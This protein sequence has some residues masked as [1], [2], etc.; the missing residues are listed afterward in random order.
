MNNKDVLSSDWHLS[1]VNRKNNWKLKDLPNLTICV[2]NYNSERWLKNFLSHILSLQYPKEKISIHFVDNGST[3]NTVIELEKFI[4]ENRDE[5]QSVKLFEQSNLGYGAGNDI[6]IRASKDE[7]VLVVNVDT[8]LDTLSLLRVVSVAVLDDLKVACWE[9]RQTPYEH[10]KFYDP[11]TLYTNWVSHACVLIRKS[12]YLA[13]GGYDLTIFMYGED[14]EI[15]YRFR[16]HGY[17]LRYIPTAL[18][19]HHVVFDNSDLRPHQISGS[20]AANVLLRY[21]YG[22]MRA[23]IA[24]ELLLF[25][26]SLRVAG[27]RQQQ[28]WKKA[29]SL[30][31][32]NRRHFLNIPISRLKIRF[33]I[34]RL[35]Y[36][37]HRAGYDLK[38]VPFLGDDNTSPLVSVVVYMDEP[39]PSHYYEAI[40]SV[41]NQTYARIEIVLV[42]SNTAEQNR[43]LLREF[44]DYK[45]NIRCLSLQS[46]ENPSLKISTLAGEFFMI[47][48]TNELLFADHVET[49][50]SAL[51]EKKELCAKSLAWIVY[52]KKSSKDDVGLNLKMEEEISDSSYKWGLFRKDNFTEWG[53]FLLVPNVQKFYKRLDVALCPNDILI[54]PKTTSII[55]RVK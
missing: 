26:T 3:D 19:K 24:G 42:G 47:L 53:D 12:A 38:Q 15:S 8:E 7:Y 9:L 37:K 46:D 21:R 2:V 32:K 30:V 54:I 50:M 40:L 36:G 49:L 45:I 13:I 16:K 43:D 18:I 44:S 51:F 20:V 23:I 35:N 28:A 25:K 29:R 39:S 55:K 22:G 31:N 52:K 33:P 4:N 5:F 10:P 48:T 34:N 17:Q 41:L 11:V 27:S 1:Y 14:V 6:A